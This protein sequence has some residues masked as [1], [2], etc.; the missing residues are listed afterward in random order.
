MSTFKSIEEIDVWNEA[1]E[2]AVDIYRITNLD[3]FSHDFSLKDQPRR[4]ALSISSNI[5]EG[6]E[7]ETTKEFIRFLYFAKGS[8]GELR[9]QLY[10]SQ[11]INFLPNEE[12]ETLYTASK[13]LSGQIQSLITYL[14]TTIQISPEEPERVIL[15]GVS[16]DGQ[17]EASENSLIELEQL[18]RTAGGL[19]IDT[20]SQSRKQADTK[21]YIGKGKLQFLS[22]LCDEQKAD[23]LIF[24]DELTAAQQKTY[25][26]KFQ[27]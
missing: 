16:R 6:Y 20:L 18:T 24:D 3:A 13:K 25:R 22:N 10:L 23:T 19:V 9:S 12:F 11:K 17:R 5:A 26:K 21:Y 27:K 14:K 7:R 2:L 4:S 1:V 15:V 8:C